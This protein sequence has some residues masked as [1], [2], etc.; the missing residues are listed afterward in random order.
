MSCQN[1]GPFLGTLNNR[2]RTIIGTPKHFDNH[3]PGCSRL[4]V[5]ISV[6]LKEGSTRVSV[7][8]V[9]SNTKT[10]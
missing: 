2:C 8:V 3:P 1:Y 5:K 9:G 6:G 4:S 10:Y 7:Q